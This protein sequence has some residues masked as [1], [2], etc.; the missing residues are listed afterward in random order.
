MKLQIF[1]FESFYEFLQYKVS[2]FLS[3]FFYNTKFW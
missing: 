1:L 3:N 2:D